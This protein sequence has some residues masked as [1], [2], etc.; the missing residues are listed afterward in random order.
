MLIFFRCGYIDYQKTIVDN[1]STETVSSVY[2]DRYMSD[3]KIG[4]T[5]RRVITN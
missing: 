5:R 1:L 3:I 2:K 4:E